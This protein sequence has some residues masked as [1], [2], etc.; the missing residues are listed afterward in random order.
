MFEAA[1]PGD[2]ISYVMQP[3]DQYYTLLGT[4]L[5]SDGGPDLFLLNGGAQ[6]RARFENAVKLDDKMGDLKADLAGSAGIF[7]RERASMPCR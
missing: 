1:H 7:R 3:N 6:A 4:A 5:A 2:T